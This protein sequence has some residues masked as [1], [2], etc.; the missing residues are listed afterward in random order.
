MACPLTLGVQKMGVC[1]APWMVKSPRME[2]PMESRS[3]PRLPNSEAEAQPPPA[4]F[5]EQSH[6]C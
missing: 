2:R 5:V 4:S 6:S 3:E 1:S